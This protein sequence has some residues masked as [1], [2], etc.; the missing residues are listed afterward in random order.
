M[1]TLGTILLD[2]CHNIPGQ[3]A[4]KAQAEHF[5]E[6]LQ[7]VED[8]E[9]NLQQ[10]L[11]LKEELPRL[12]VAGVSEAD[13]GGDQGVQDDG[14]DDGDVVKWA[15]KQPENFVLDHTSLYYRANIIS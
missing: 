14:Q 13:G 4:A 6:R 8:G 11:V 12:L 9:A 1:A 10:T 2:I 15:L 5:K 7:V 3:V